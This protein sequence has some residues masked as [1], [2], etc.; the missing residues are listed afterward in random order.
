MRADLSRDTFDA[1]KQYVSVVL[2]QGRVL[3]DADFNEQVDIDRDR[4][5]V[6]DRDT[7]GASGAPR[8]G[9]GFEVV[10]TEDGTDLVISPGRFHL[11]GLVVDNAPQRTLATATSATAM[12][13]ETTVLDGRTVGAGDVLAVGLA[14]DATLVTVSAVAGEQVSTAAAHGIPAG[15]SAPV[16][17]RVSVGRQPHVWPSRAAAGGSPLTVD[18]SPLT[19]GRY[20]AVLRTS[21]REVSAV[22]DPALPEPALGGPDTTLR[23]RTVWQVLLAPIPGGGG[24]SSWTAPTS[25]V[26]LRPELAAP[27][28]DTGDCTLPAESAYQGVVN[29]LYRVEV[30]GVAP[31]TGAVTSILWDRDNASTVSLVDQLGQPMT[32]RSFG[33]DATRGFAT[34]SLVTVTDQ[35]RDWDGAPQQ[36]G[37]PSDP[38]AEVRTLKVTPVP[39]VDV[40]ATPRIRRWCGQAAVIAGAPIPLELGL[41]VVLDGGSARPGDHWV[42]PARTALG[43]NGGI[44]WPVDEPGGYRALPAAGAQE[45]WCPL[46]VLDL[47]GTGWTAPVP[48][49][50][51]RVFP[52]LTTITATDVSYDDSRVDLGATDVQQ[53]IEALWHRTGGC[54]IVL[55]PGP[56][57][58]EPL[59]ALPDGLDA[60]VCFRAGEFPTDTRVV[61]ANKGHLVLEGVGIG[62]VLR[63]ARDEVA[64]QLD[65]CAQ[66]TVRDMA[67]SGDGSQGASAHLGGALSITSCPQVLVEHVVAGCASAGGPVGT[68]I[69]ISGTDSATAADPA[70]GAALPTRVV[71]RDCTLTPGEYQI[72][73]AV[74]DVEHC[75]VSGVVVQPPPSGFT[76]LGRM[77]ARLRRR[78]ATAMLSQLT[79]VPGTPA[80]GEGVSGAMKSAAKVASKAVA[81]KTAPA[82]V[83]AQKTSPAAVAGAPAGVRAT[84]ARPAGRLEHLDVGGL[85]FASAGRLA[86]GWRAV[87]TASPAPA[88]TPASTVTHLRRLVDSALRPSAPA[89][90]APLRAALEGAVSLRLPPVYQG[91]VISGA[92]LGTVVVRHCRV[93]QAVMG[94]HIGVSRSESAKAAPL[95]ATRVEVC[96]N[97]VAVLL[98]SEGARSRHG[99]FVGNTRSLLVADNTLTF[100]SQ[101]LSDVVDS[102]A[103]RV[104]GYLGSDAVVRDNHATGFPLCIALLVYGEPSAPLRFARWV[105]RGTFGENVNRLLVAAYRGTGNLTFALSD[106]VPPS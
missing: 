38:K 97:S 54:T 78:F 56:G 46:A 86:Q 24:C 79:T 13:L 73:L 58:A 61:V 93:E 75:D 88:G 17:R 68:C 98:P 55:T 26:R 99:I 29:S 40:E 57:W 60:R 43:G 32:L 63:A 14:A 20:V 74:R 44:D 64:L 70:Y 9:G 8:D 80:P 52:G 53:A 28:A 100:T 69:T 101:A 84:F 71:V 2:Q 5:R 76:D 45:Q 85:S 34:A 94:I 87:L 33:P 18:G 35:H 36:V 66:V 12:T 105:L 82:K 4:D 95:Y 49:D 83:A 77:P 89:V 62:T 22:D 102:A 81:K 47:T 27:A 42:I 104:A 31:A 59:L 92:H 41:S 103:I 51:R 48:S 11:G 21:V 67:F 37:T 19:P 72:G 3:L 91:V 30:N 16:W 1:S 7:V 10:P 15:T 25:T 6:A 96:H 65:H 50:C 106:N 90:V 39:E 23:R